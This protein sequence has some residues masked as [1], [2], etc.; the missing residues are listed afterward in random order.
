MG[1]GPSL[2]IVHGG[3]GDR[4]RWQP[5]LPLFAAHFN[6]CAMDRRGHGQSERGTDYGLAREFEDVAAAVN[7]R[8]GPVFVLGHS[9]GGVFALE[10]S[11][12]T[13]KIAKLALYEPPLQDGDH[14]AIAD[15]MEEMIQAGQREEALLTFLREIVQLSP[16]EI[17][18][19]KARPIWPER[20]AGID[21]QIREVRALSQYQFDAQRIRKARIPTLLLTGSKTRSP[22]LKQAIASLMRVLPNRQLVVL[23]GEEHNAMDTM[24]QRFADVVTKFLLKR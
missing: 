8:P 23:E 10:A 17:A 14:T 12:L 3:T 15:R 1:R 20:V 24:P 22:Q 2:L 21:I 7:S 4:R 19:M 16:A 18:A 9:I 13:S 5:L 11:F 6:V